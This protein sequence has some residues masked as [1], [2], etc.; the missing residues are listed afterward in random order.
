MSHALDELVGQLDRPEI[1]AQIAQTLGCRETPRA[2]ADVMRLAVLGV[3]PDL[4]AGLLAQLTSCLPSSADP[5]VG[6]SNLLRF[7]EASRSPQALLALFERDPSSLPVLVKI[8][9]ISQ[10]WA[11]LLIADP[12]SFDLLR[13]TESLPVSRHSGRRD[14]RRVEVTFDSQQTARI[15]HFAHKQRETM[16]CVRRFHRRYRSKLS[17]TN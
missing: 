6:L 15:L 9:S 16:P 17:Q 2:A 5:D 8:V 10:S 12:E 3:S 14:V 4:L 7:I 13:M 1:A 11:D